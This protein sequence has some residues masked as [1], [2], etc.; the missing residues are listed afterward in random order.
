MLWRPIRDTREVEASRGAARAGSQGESGEC[1]AEVGAHDSGL[2]FEV[3]EHVAEAVVVDAQS[4][5]QL[6]AGDGALGASESLQNEFV[7]V[8]CVGDGGSDRGVGVGRFVLVLELEVSGAAIWERDEA[9]L[10]GFF[11]GSGSVL[12]GESEYVCGASEVCP[13]IDPGM[14]VA[15]AT[16]SLSELGAYALGHVMDQDDGERMRALQLTEISE[17]MGDFPGVIFVSCDRRDYVTADL[18]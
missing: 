1:E 12:E 9:Q 16:Q 3:Q 6:G 18:Q 13:V 10:D 17:E 7:E 11:G 15:G 8:R 14:K 5:A 2:T 4:G